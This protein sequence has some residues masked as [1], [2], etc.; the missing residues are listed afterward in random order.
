MSAVYTYLWPLC[1]VP[2]C[3]L[4]PA[5]GGHIPGLAISDVGAKAGSEGLK[6]RDCSPCTTR[7]FSGSCA[8]RRFQTASSFLRAEFTKRAANYFGSCMREN[9]AGVLWIWGSDYLTCWTWTQKVLDEV[10]SLA[11]L[12]APIGLYLEWFSCACFCGKAWEQFLVFVPWGCWFVVAKFKLI[13]KSLGNV[14]QSN[15]WSQA[16]VTTVELL[17]WPCFRWRP[18]TPAWFIASDAW[19]SVY[20]VVCLD[21]VPPNF[22]VIDPLI[23]FSH[24]FFHFSD[25]QK[26]KSCGL[27]LTSDWHSFFTLLNN[28]Y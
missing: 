27:T 22:C 28:S 25:K 4:P 19:L 8:A 26:N 10:V 12:T 11:F 17:S 23:L 3:C 1:V 16:A 7:L 15:L 20:L 9:A 21:G 6:R 24:S 14:P 18:V 5:T 2:W 13:S